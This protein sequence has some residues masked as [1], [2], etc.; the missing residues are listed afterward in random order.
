[1]SSLSSSQR[2]DLLGLM[3]FSE[4]LGVTLEHAAS[5]RVVGTLAWPAERCTGGGVLHGGAIMALAD[6]IGA[7]CAYL[8]LF[9][10]NDHVDH[11]VQDQLLPRRSLRARAGKSQATPCR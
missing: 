9:G 3:P 10:G 5:D 8:N 2:A 11:R 1:M 7:I 6:T 4:G